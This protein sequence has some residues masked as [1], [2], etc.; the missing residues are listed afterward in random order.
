[1]TSDCNIVY[2]VTY[3]FGST[4]AGPV[5][6]FIKYHKYLKK[7]GWELIFITTTDSFN[8]FYQDNNGIKS[9]HLEALNS[10][11]LILKVEDFVNKLNH[12]NINLIFFNVNYK[13][14]FNFFR[15]KLKGH[16]LIYVSTM[17]LEF[18]DLNYFK[19]LISRIVHSLLYSLMN[20]IVSSTNLL[21][22]DFIKLGITK[23]KLLVINNGVDTNRFSKVNLEKK[24]SIRKLYSI[25]LDRHIF[26]YVGLFIYRKGVLELLKTFTQ[27]Y[28]K[29]R[30]FQFVM[31]GH[32]MDHHENTPNFL[33]DWDLEKKKALD[34]GWLK[35]FPF[36]NS[37]DEFYKLADSFV[38]M[39]RIEGMPNVILE[40]MSSGLPILTTKFNGFSSNYGLNGEDYLFLSYNYQKNIR[41]INNLMDNK[42]L[43]NLLSKNSRAR[44]INNFDINHS[45]NKYIDIFN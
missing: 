43:L 1:M 39:S 7:L 26:L 14:Y 29:R 20:K 9:Y 33:V 25:D 35:I 15:M 37:V 24:K 4:K 2:V 32:E 5:I 12:A 42:S 8:G 38:F 41:T 16:N 31:V 36:T 6:R 13:N 44:S 30:D 21:K 28:N 17:K 40:A 23:D 18:D 19:G 11:D 45:I 34:A 3:N 27:L 10:N 22:G